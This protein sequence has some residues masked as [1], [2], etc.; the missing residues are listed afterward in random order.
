[1]VLVMINFLKQKLLKIPQPSST[2]TSVN[3]DI[4]QPNIT[5]NVAVLFYREN[6]LPLP[7]APFQSPPAQTFPTPHPPAIPP[8]HSISPQPPSLP[9]NAALI[10]QILISLKFFAPPPSLSPPNNKA[11]VKL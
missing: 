5:T 10:P 8:L 2:H 9:H 1:M 4:F 6:T 7:S 3:E 11:R